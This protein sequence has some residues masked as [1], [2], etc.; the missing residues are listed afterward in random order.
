MV[1]VS[2]GGFYQYPWGGC[3]GFV[4]YYLV[5]SED[6]DGS[7]RFEIYF[8][9]SGEDTFAGFMSMQYMTKLAVDF[10]KVFFTVFHLAIQLVAT[11]PG[12]YFWYF[13]YPGGGVRT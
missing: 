5:V 10:F 3:A 12:Y 7:L 4:C 1:V 13:F 9:W 2:S 8:I 11:K 6:G